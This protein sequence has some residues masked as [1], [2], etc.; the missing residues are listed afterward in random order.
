M[1][2]EENEAFWGRLREEYV[3]SDLSLKKL[4]EKHGVSRRQL[5]RRCAREGWAAQRER[6]SGGSL[7]ED[8]ARRLTEAVERA[9][10]VVREALEDE[11]QFHRYLVKTKA[12]GAEEL[13]ERIFR[14]LDTKSLKEVT[15]VL[16]DLK[17]MVQEAGSQNAQVRVVFEAGE[18]DWNE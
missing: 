14:K 3:R 5:E 1:T 7:T 10:E 11:Q 18:E 13:E 9:L 16:K 17:A 2:R 6:A 15:A 8:T 12:D 4:A